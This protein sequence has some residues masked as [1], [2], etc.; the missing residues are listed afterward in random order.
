MSCTHAADHEWP[1]PSR[2]VFWNV[3]MREIRVEL[4]QD[5]PFIRTCQM[6]M[7]VLSCPAELDEVLLIESHPRWHPIART[8]VKLEVGGC[9]PVLL[10]GE[11]HARSVA[12]DRSDINPKRLGL[13]GGLGSGLRSKFSRAKD[14]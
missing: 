12:D 1:R 9:Y 13:G 8:R 3:L 10:G 6:D 4:I 7:S 14:K 5:R 11:G 2:P